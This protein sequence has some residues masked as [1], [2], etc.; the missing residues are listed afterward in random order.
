MNTDFYLKKL[1]KFIGGTI[2]NVAQD[3]NGYFGIIIEK[4]KEKNI[5]WFL[6]DDEG[7]N[8]GSFDIQPIK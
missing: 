7:N 5:I 1:K 2:I 3:S 4:D 8:S 6:S